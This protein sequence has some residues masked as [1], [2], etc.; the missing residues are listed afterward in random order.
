V[1]AL[2]TGMRKLP[3]EPPE[4]AGRFDLLGLA[5]LGTGL[6]A[7][8]YGL[9]E[10][11]SGGNS[12]EHVVLPL[13]V[14]GALVAGFVAHALHID[15][16]LLDMRLYTN[17]AFAASMVTMFCLGAALFGSII[18]MPLYF[19]TVRHEDALITG[20][21]IAPRG[22]GSAIGTWRSAKWMERFGCGAT[23][24]VGSAI[25][26]LS[27][28]P[29]LFL[30][31]D[32]SYWI[33]SA[34]MVVQGIGFGLSVMPASTAAFRTLRTSQIND[35]APQQN[36]IMR[37]GASI[38]TAILIVVLQQKLDIAGA[39]PSA[40]ASAFG[41]TFWLVIGITAMAVI[42]TIGLTIIERRHT[43][44]AV[45]HDDV[46]GEAGAHLAPVE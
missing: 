16:P 11:G 35:A 28:V 29:F 27:T 36:I 5:L 34:A 6:V 41:M 8:T 20:L 24:F 40:Q 23:A 4:D 37:L 25:T 38:G 46:L 9:A 14:G 3:S 42:A 33:T 31:A 1:L 17:R 30:H 32:T 21:L 22:L 26:L 43:S 12:L 39:F 10:I 15:R 18:L 44:D 13:V 45:E 19:Q 7:V 2:I